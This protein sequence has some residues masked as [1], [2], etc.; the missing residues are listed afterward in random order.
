MSVEL[1]G[2]LVGEIQAAKSSTV[3]SGYIQNS[4]LSPKCEAL[5]LHAPAGHVPARVVDTWGYLRDLIGCRTSF[6]TSFSENAPLFP[7][8]P[9]RGIGP[10]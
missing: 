7:S 2:S 1:A 4:G 5:L 9:S 10:H 3:Y 6:C 8:V